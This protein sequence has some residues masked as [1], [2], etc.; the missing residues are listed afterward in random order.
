MPRVYVSIGSNIDRD[1]NIRGALVELRKTFGELQCSSV[2]E[3][4]AVGF[5]GDAF[6]NLVAGLDTDLDVQELKAEFD[7]I[8]KQFGR[9]AQS[10]R[11]APRTLDLDL[12][13]YGDM[14][15]TTGQ[16]DI[17]RKEI[18]E[19]EFVLLPLAEI[20][21]EYRHPMTG[22]RFRDLWERFPKNLKLEK[23][24]WRDKA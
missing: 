20:A 14:I 6:Y 22:E 12:L 17:P 16:Y 4:E 2:Y 10:R 3:S 1:K 5:E 24:E 15:D 18:D 8:E 21:G 9:T 13:L 11:F 7:R 19:Y 23:I